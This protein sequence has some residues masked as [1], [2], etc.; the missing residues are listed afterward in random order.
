VDPPRP[1]PAS[2]G[3]LAPAYTLLRAAISDLLEDQD[4][5][6]VRDSDVKRRM[7]ALQKDFDEA[8]LGFSKF[9][10]FLRQAHDHEVVDLRKGEG[11]NYH[12]ALGTRT[13]PPE[14]PV[15]RPRDSGV[16]ETVERDTPAAGSPVASQD[17]EPS[18]QVPEGGQP[19]PSVHDGDAVIR[20]LRPRE[21]STRSRPGADEPPPLF[22]GQVVSRGSRSSANGGASGT[23]SLDL[24]C[25]EAPDGSRQHRTVPDQL[26]CRRRKKDG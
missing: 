21:A 19:T 18:R 2:E 1:L 8:A 4:S 10:K 25:A 16:E 7:L 13:S 12:V 23:Q 15:E 6:A 3:A 14:V 24:G 17:S 9:S 22:E 20:R 5:D 26:L 11:G